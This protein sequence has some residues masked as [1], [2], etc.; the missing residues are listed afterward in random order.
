MT[1]VVLPRWYSGKESA[2]QC[3]RFRR[4]RFNPWVKK[5]SWS[6]KWQ[7]TPVFLPTKVW[8]R[9][10]LVGYGPWGCKE[11]DTAEYTGNKELM[12]SKAIEAEKIVHLRNCVG[13]E[14]R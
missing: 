7:P 10:S 4:G 8:G 12:G 11:S 14:S 5:I 2:C 1:P 3:R 13:K 9:R 6:R